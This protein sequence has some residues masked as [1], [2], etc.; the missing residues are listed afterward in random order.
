MEAITK[1]IVAVAVA[2]L[3]TGLFAWAQ[4]NQPPRAAVAAP[5]FVLRDLNKR[6]VRLTDF[7]G[8]GLLVAFFLANTAPCR[9]QMPALID[10]QS[11][12]GN[13]NFTVI[14]LAL[15]E[16]GAVALKAFAATNH[17]NFPILLADYDVIEGF[18]GLTAV[19]TLIT[20]TPDHLIRQRYVGV[21]DKSVLAA[22][23]K[24]MIA[25]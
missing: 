5:K 20:V 16:D 10:L 25:K 4:T 21:T 8:K 19:P 24:A 13:T 1:R 17:V 11:Q 18:G 7:R 15:D 14:G 2:C 22:D 12:Y 9:Q 6:E 3:L 23:I